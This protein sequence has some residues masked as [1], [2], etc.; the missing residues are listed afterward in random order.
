MIFLLQVA[1]TNW[2]RIFMV[3]TGRSNA[4]DVLSIPANEAHSKSVY[5]TLRNYTTLD[6][7]RL[8]NTYTKFLFVRHPFERLL[9]AY[10]NKLEQNYLSSKYFKERIGKYIVQNFRAGVGNTSDNLGND[11]TFQVSYE[12]FTLIKP[13]RLGMSLL[14]IVYSVPEPFIR[15]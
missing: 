1:C 14:L 8:L 7:T 15:I 11:V 9:S 6:A 5:L 4:S 12:P 10:R 2:K 13:P 3:L